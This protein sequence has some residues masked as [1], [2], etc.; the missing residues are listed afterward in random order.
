MLKCNLAVLLAERKLKISKVAADTGISRT[1][2]TALSSNQSQGIQFDTLNTLCSHLRVTPAE[3]FCYASFEFKTELEKTG[4]NTFYVNIYFLPSNKRYGISD[5]VY[6]FS[7][8]YPDYETSE[9]TRP[10]EVSIELPDDDDNLR[11]L[12]RYMKGLSPIF[13][14][15]L[16][17]QI[18]EDL[19]NAYFDDGYEEGD[20][21][22]NLQNE[23]KDLL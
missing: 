22:L 7:E 3:F 18:C 23:L 10:I 17:Q 11:K 9:V 12:R 20:C 4:D 14:R 21:I 2:L 15:D 13:K 19:Y 1:T 6:L 16:E 5:S 8:V